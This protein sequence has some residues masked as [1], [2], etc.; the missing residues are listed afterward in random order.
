MPVKKLVNIEKNAKSDDL[1][2]ETTPTEEEND[3]TIEKK[4]KK[5]AHLVKKSV[6]YAE[7]RNQVIDEIFNIIGLPNKNGVISVDDFGPKVVEIEKLVD[8]IKI[9]FCCSTYSYFKKQHEDDV[10]ACLSL[11]KSV[12]KEM[13]Y[14]VKAYTE[15]TT[16]NKVRTAKRMLSIHNLNV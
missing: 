9:A 6:A 7:L 2:I 10:S 1:L 14:S 13:K 8:N 12:L 11:I 5:G 4:Q 15:Y 3:G 16:H